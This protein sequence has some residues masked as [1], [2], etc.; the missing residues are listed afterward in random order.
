[1]ANGP[2]GKAIGIIAPHCERCWRAGRTVTTMRGMFR[3]QLDV[4]AEFGF[5]FLLTGFDWLQSTNATIP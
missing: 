2:R 5:G 3:A 4:A 1:M